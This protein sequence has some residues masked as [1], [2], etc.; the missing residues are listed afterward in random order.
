MQGDADQAHHT[1]AAMR[2]GRSTSLSQITA[3]TENRMEKIDTMTI[4]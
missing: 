2:F 4:K 3:L 1:T